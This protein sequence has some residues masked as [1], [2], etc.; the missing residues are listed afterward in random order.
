MA[1]VAALLFVCLSAPASAEDARQILLRSL[2]AR[3]VSFTGTQVSTDS[4]RPTRRPVLQTVYRKN[5]IVR[6]E[7][8]SGQTMF[9][10][11]ESTQVYFPRQG[12]VEKRPSSPAS[13]RRKILARSLRTGQVTLE[14][15]PDEEIAGRAA[16]VIALKSN[17]GL[18]RK[19]WIDREFLVHL[20]IEELHSDGHRSTTSFQ[21]IDFQKAPPQALLSFRPPPGAVVVD[22]GPGRPL[23]AAQATAMAARWGGL[24]EPGFLPPAYRLRGHYRQMVQKQ[25]LLVSVYVDPATN[26]TLSVFQGPV[27]GMAGVTRKE[28]D[29]LRV[30]AARKGPAEIIL[31]GP[32]DEDL[33]RV[34]DSMA[35]SP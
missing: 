21:T 7:F 1:T 20:R 19:L 8:P 32:A 29:R 33:K 10:D 6:I 5:N 16:H 28:Q 14:Q 11:G 12:I 26:R 4:R 27:M 22:A 34:M 31:V 18:N 30:L 13:Q 3:P 17:R 23:Q 35:A 25:E 9:D 2:E 24:L 15:F